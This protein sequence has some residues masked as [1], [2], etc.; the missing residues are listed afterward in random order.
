MKRSIRLLSGFA[1]AAFVAISLS[2][3][4]TSIE[5]VYHA[6]YKPEVWS[7]KP[8]IDKVTKQIDDAVVEKMPRVGAD[9]MGKAG[10]APTQAIKDLLADV[11]DVV[12]E[13]ED[14]ESMDGVNNLIFFGGSM[15]KTERDELIERIYAAA[16]ER[17]ADIEAAVVAWETEVAAENARIQAAEEEAARQAAAAQAAAAK[18]KGG[19]GSYT[20]VP[21]ESFEARLARIYGGLGI[22][23][24]TYSIGGCSIGNA[25]YVVGTGKMIITT[26]LATK[27]DCYLRM[28][29][30]H[31]ARHYQQ[32]LN[33]QIQFDANGISNRDWLESDAYSYGYQYGC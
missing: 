7:S 8:I 21:G 16:D 27:S 29:F 15:F 14:I 1:A 31:E 30:A 33:G 6:Q 19:G 20:P 12:A 32:E 13:A 5:P 23:K 2:S 28:V 9:R 4:S 25:C 22:T 17:V 10:A 24:P 26:S 18:K 11:E 3:A